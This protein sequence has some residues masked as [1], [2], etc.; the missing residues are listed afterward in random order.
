MSQ[1][2]NNKETIEGYKLTEKEK[3]EIDRIF[4]KTTKDIMDKI[5]EKENVRTK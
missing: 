4:K 3:E 1:Y 2:H 5:K